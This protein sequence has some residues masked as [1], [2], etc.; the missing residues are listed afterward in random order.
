[1][2]ST[3]Y[4]KL[5]AAGSLKGLT[6]PWSVAPVRLIPLAGSVETHGAVGAVVKETSAPVKAIWSLLMAARR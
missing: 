4:S 3:Q 5:T 2:G 6:V 1:L